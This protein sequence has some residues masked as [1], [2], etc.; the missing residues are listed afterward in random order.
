MVYGL[1]FMVESS[2]FRAY[3]FVHEIGST[4]QPHRPPLAPT[5]HLHKLLDLR[6][7]NGVYVRRNPNT[8]WLLDLRQK[9]GVYARRIPDMYN[10]T[11]GVDI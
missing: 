4:A 7:K 3:T 9:N 8:M 6:Q 11:A 5:M 10:R 2:G 1:V